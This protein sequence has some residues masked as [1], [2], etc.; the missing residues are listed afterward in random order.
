MNERESVRHVAAES[1]AALGSIYHFF[2]GREDEMSAEVIRAAGRVYAAL[3]PMIFDAEPDVVVVTRNAFAGAAG[4]LCGT[5]FADACPIATVALEVASTNE[6]LR[7]TTTHQS[8]R[9]QGCPKKSASPGSPP[10]LPMWI[11][12]NNCGDRT[13]RE[14]INNTSRMLRKLKEVCP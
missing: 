11:S 5:G 10:S 6:T 2:P 3:V 1:G 9:G 14:R 13:R 4:R 8:R 7:L 12:V